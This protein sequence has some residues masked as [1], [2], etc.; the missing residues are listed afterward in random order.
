MHPARLALRT[1]GLVSFV[2]LAAGH[3]RAED[4]RQRAAGEYDPGGFVGPQAC[5]ACHPQHYDEWQG[6]P[7][8]YA[9]ADP[10]FWYANEQSYEDNGIEHFCVTCHAPIADLVDAE[11]EGHS[12]G[13]T[14]LL[15]VA[16]GGVDCETCH[17]IF[18]VTRGVKQLTG[19]EDHYFGPIADPEGSPHGAEFEPA[20]EQAAFCA[21]CHDVKLSNPDNNDLLQIEFTNTEWDE[22]NTAAGGTPTE[23]AIATCQECHMPSYTGPAAADGR[24]REVHRH[25]FAGVDVALIPFADSHRQYR[26]TQD[27]LRTAGA[28]DAQVE[29]RSVRVD[30]T[31]LIVG[32]DLPSGSAHARAVWVHLRVVGADGTVYLESGDVDTNGDLRDA[33]SEIDPYGDP[34]IA[35][36]ESVFR[37]Y[38][39]DAE[40]EEVVAAYGRVVRVERDM[41]ASGE[42]R[43]IWY[44]L[45]GA[46]PADAAYP[47]HVDAKLLFRPASNFILRE[48]GMPA[49]MIELVPTFEMAAAAT[50][51]DG[52][53]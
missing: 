27:L 36:G 37:E 26:A 8:A 30:V 6:S 53:P 1:L 23:P 41:L 44:D 10:V 21:P 28:I 29:G 14:D 46:L 19:C 15:A 38:M 48:I 3:A 39:Y 33:H 49:E 24:D 50:S 25:G 32:H 17:R 34:W 51:I 5:A 16:Q 18:D 22:A 9:V 12:T 2:A 43:S 47:V 13:R 42:V 35:N 45:D 40:G 11:P 20:F 4:C 52:E 31:N 7:H